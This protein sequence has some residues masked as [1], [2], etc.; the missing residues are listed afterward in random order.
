M[1]F[2]SQST[3][4]EHKRRFMAFTLEGFITCRAE[5][6]FNAIEIEFADV[7]TNRPVRFNDYTG[8]T[9]AAMGSSAAIFASTGDGQAAGEA[10]SVVHY[11]AFASWTSNSDWTTSLPVGEQA[12][13]RSSSLLVSSFASCKLRAS[14]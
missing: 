11:R 7:H 6:A 8:Y 2:V 9:M 5:A 12:W 3:K 1:A 4:M 14:N 10:T 13:P